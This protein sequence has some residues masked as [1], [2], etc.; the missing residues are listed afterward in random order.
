MSA[1]HAQ[2]ARG[3]EVARENGA[4]AEEI[5]HLIYDTAID[6]S[7]WPEMVLKVHDSFEQ[8]E[9]ESGAAPARLQ[10]LQV[11]FAKGL[12]ISERMLA[13]QERS[14]L[15]DRLLD[16]IAL[17]VELFGHDGERFGVL[18]SA[19]EA[20]VISHATA[21][22][23]VL[24][25]ERVRELGLPPR[26][27]Y[28]R[29]GFTQAPEDIAARLGRDLALRPSR[30][31]LLA[32]FL[33]HGNLRRTAE[34]QGWSYE[35]ARTYFKALCEEA[36]VSGQVDLLRLLL[37]NPA[38]VLK[39]PLI[40]PS[41]PEIRRLIDRPDDGVIEV[42]QLGREDAY[43]IVHFDALSGGAIDLLNCPERYQPLLDALGAR[44]VL[45]C[46]PGHFL[47]GFQQLSG[48]SGYANDLKIVCDAL[49]IDR[50]SILAYSF[51]SVAALG[52]AAGL[53]ERVDRVTLASVCYPD[54]VATDWRDRDF[55]YQMTHII[56]R[57]WPGLHRRV[58]PFLT[59]SVLQN[60]DSYA[61]RAAAQ[62]RC[63]HEKAI[64][65]DPV[66]IARSRAMLEERIAQ[67]MEGLIQESRI[68][69]QALDFELSDL[70]MPV[71]LFHGGCDQVHPLDGAR[72]L[73]DQLPNAR[74]TELPE[75]GHAFI[76]AEWD[77]LLRAAIAAEFVVP[78]PS[79]RGM[80]L[81]GH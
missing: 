21:P 44:I 65:L 10:D 31:K 38:R 2:R 69:A 52:A 77:W 3:G 74:L 34:E 72:A 27:A 75:R 15:Q 8:D 30:Q 60:V 22:T 71:E 62:A 66:V 41:I 79:R 25:A 56:G 6:N 7:L 46:R 26:V 61:R 55:F 12:Q 70:Q 54:F 81:D 57:R 78:P 24:D 36:G 29:I 49:G 50:F 9:A 43:P 28:A 37:L 48:A 42:F 14:D 4:S 63:A 73:A 53:P 16:N 32:G 67:G 1:D 58:I 47:S 13:L 59:K 40:K 80:L 23:F 35:T 45:P 18:G 19:P 51:G 33:R 20:G 39:A 17:R 76:Y 68:A 64:L 5:I 11:H